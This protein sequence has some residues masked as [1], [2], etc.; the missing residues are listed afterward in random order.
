MLKIKYHETP[1]FKN[2]TSV[3]FKGNHLSRC[4]LALL[5]NHY[6]REKGLFEVLP[7][8]ESCYGDKTISAGGQA[9]LMKSVWSYVSEEPRDVESLY[10]LNIKY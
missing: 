4:G 5:Q 1:R 7:P 3:I 9:V 10:I 2:S 8:E 6:L